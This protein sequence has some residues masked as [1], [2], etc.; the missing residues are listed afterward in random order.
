[1]DE[2]VALTR[3]CLAVMP[4]NNDLVI[5]VVA[6]LDR[7][8][9]RK[10]A[11]ELFAQVWGTF[12]KLAEEN[13]ESG[14][15]HHSA[16]WLA[17]GCRRE[18]DAAF[19]HAKKAAELDPELKA[20]QEGLAEVHFRRGDRDQAVGLMKELTAVDRRN[21]HFRRQL[22]RYQ[23]APFDSPLPDADDD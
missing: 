12:R 8:G 16:A 20:H 11:D 17:A 21:H 5:P 1:V 9:R 6:E 15:A 18:L 7:L 23:S 3:E 4:G 10:E 2:A 22:E 13:P 19:D 14:W